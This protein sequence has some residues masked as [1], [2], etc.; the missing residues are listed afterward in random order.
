[1]VQHQPSVQVVPQFLPI[2]QSNDVQPNVQFDESREVPPPTD[3]P[4]SGETHGFEESLSEAHGRDEPGM[5][6]G[7][8]E[9]NVD[10]DLKMHVSSISILDK[11]CLS[12]YSFPK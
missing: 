4:G 7:M 10:T 3:E 2:P 12:L 6:V 11:L 8:V 5:D 1:M 9:E